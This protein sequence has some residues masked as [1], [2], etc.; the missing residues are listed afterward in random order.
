MADKAQ[1]YAESF[2]KLIKVPTVTNSDRKNF[3]AFRKVLAEEFPAVYSACEVI[4]PGGEGSDALM[5]KWKGRSSDRPVVLMAHQDVVPAV[6]GDWKYPPYSATVADGKIWGRGTMDC[7]NTLFCTI[8]SVNE[9]IEEGFTPAQDVYLCY[10][11]NE[12]TSGH[13]AAYCRD[14]LTAHGV[15]PAVAIDEGGAIVEEAFPGMTKPFAMVGIIEKGYCDVKFV[16]RSKGGHSSSP[17]KHTPFARLAEFINYCE[18]HTVFKPRMTTA[19]RDMLKG[20]SSG[21]TGALAFVTRHVD[22]FKPLIVAV[23]PKL[24]PFGSALLGTTMTFTMAQGSAAPNV[25]PQAAS[26]V[27]NLRFA[28]GD[29]SKE[30]IEKLRRIAE[31]Y[32]IETEV[33]ECRDATPMVDVNSADYKYFVD[34]VARV[35]PDCGAAP[36][37]IFGGTDCRT[38][39]TITPCA[40]RCTPCKL[41]A[42]QLASMHAANENIDISSL[43]GGVAFFKTYLK[44]Y[45]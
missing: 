43:V 24:T 41:S 42:E 5:F 37:L 1:V 18:T 39:Q 10:S 23:L 20:L 2:A 36:Y 3:A 11:D 44:G 14:W 19:A 29:D 4:M 40:L 16:V 26:V 34:T 27:A 45:K 25:I 9:L 8:R 13:G 28:P 17:P 12:E 6:D 22:F 31:R 35:F 21:L 32:D 33:M 38:M 30:C 7:K 15:K